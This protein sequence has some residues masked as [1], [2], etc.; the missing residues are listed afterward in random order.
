VSNPQIPLPQP[1]GGGNLTILTKPSQ[2]MFNM[3]PTKLTV[4]VKQ[5]KADTM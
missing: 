2:F 3:R 1:V 5:L 4:P